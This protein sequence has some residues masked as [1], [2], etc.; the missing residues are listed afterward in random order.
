MIRVGR[1]KAGGRTENPKY[2]TSYVAEIELPSIF[3]PMANS[4]TRAGMYSGA[5]VPR[6]KIQF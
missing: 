4:N 3:G 2:V 5:T 1:T 6:R